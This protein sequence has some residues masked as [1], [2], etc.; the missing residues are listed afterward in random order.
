MH[1]GKWEN[2]MM[3]GEGIFTW[4]DGRKYIGINNKYRLV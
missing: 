4:K 3:N 2:N 1:V